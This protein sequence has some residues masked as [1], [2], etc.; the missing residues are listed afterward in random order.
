MF[1]KVL[2]RKMRFRVVT[3][4]STAP[5]FWWNLGIRVGNVKSVNDRE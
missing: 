2:L 1:Q 3:V 4:Y 5:G